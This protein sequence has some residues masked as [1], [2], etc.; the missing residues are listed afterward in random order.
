MQRALSRA[1]HQASRF[2]LTT[3]LHGCRLY[4]C[5]DPGSTKVSGCR[6]C[7]HYRAPSISLTVFW[8]P[9][10]DVDLGHECSC[11]VS[12]HGNPRTTGTFIHFVEPM[13]RVLQK[14]FA[15]FNEVASMLLHGGISIPPCRR[16]RNLRLIGDVLPHF[17]RN[18]FRCAR[19][20]NG[21]AYKHAVLR[22]VSR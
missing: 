22:S 3:D 11:L 16:S 1:R 5:F 19:P 13:S 14:Q 7:A 6:S 12:L 9:P 17:S 20:W 8:C 2:L 4:G 18:S 10:Y 15:F 21:D